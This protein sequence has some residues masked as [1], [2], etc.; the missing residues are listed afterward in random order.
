MIVKND[1]IINLNKSIKNKNYSLLKQNIYKYF[2]EYETLDYQHKIIS[3]IKSLYNNKD[4][5][6]YVDFFKKNVDKYTNKIMSFD[7]FFNSKIEDDEDEDED[8]LY[9]KYVRNNKNVQI[10]NLLENY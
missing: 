9:S 3:L 1:L 8:T 5:N 2:F 4:N 7:T 10:N 6:K